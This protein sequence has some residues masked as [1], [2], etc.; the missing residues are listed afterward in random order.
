MYII[1]GLLLGAAVICSCCLHRRTRIIRR[2][3]NM[4]SAEKYCKLNALIH[5]WGFVYLPSQDILTSG[6]DAW[7]REF[8]YHALFDRTAPHFHMVFDCEPVYF[9]YQ[10]RTWMIEFWKGQYGIN[11]GGEI[12]IYYADSI[13][14]PER[15]GDTYFHSADDN[16]LLLLSMALYERGECL[17]EVSQYHWWLT[18]FSMGKYSEPENLEMRI[19]VTCPDGEMLCGLIKGLLKSGYGMDELTVRN[20]TVTLVFSEPHSGQFTGAGRSKALLQ[21]TKR[22]AQW[23]NRLLCRIYRRITRPFACTLNRLLYL[24]LMVPFVFRR[25]LCFKKNRRQKIRRQE[26]RRKRKWRV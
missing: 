3:C 14:L 1:V 23:E 4:P 12:G 25:I 18:G 10:G 6:L 22:M 11:I 5:P 9:D 8:G 16:H 17:L 7:Q 13:V 15:Y 21:W 26:I 2:I 20:L 19:S 24:Y